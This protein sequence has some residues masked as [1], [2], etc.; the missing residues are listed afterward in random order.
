MTTTLDTPFRDPPP[1]RE[2]PL[3]V[4]VS[5]GR[6]LA[7]VVAGGELDIATAPLLADIVDQLTSAPRYRRLVIDVSAVTFV[8]LHGLRLLD[9][10]TSATA[11]Q[12]AAVEVVP[13]AAVLRLRRVLFGPSSM[14]L[15]DRPVA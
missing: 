7:V 12:P 2:P 10:L 3:W 11:A 14:A 13:S 8:D 9:R 6:R 5:T 15:V 1:H 4:N